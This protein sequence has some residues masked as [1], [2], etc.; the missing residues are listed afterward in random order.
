MLSIGTASAATELCPKDP[1]P[2]KVFYEINHADNTATIF[3]DPSAPEKAWIFFA[4]YNPESL[5]NPSV[6]VTSDVSNTWS[7]DGYLPLYNSNKFQKYSP[8][9]PSNHDINSVTF[10]FTG[11]VPDT[12]TF[13]CHVAWGT[14]STEFGPCGGSIP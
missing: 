7:Y 2:V 1:A 9:G 5:Y 6:T 4:G 3:V 14:D 12:A 13:A 11:A 10:H 8:D